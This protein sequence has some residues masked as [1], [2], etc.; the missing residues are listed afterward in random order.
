MN[1]S[2][3]I[4]RA[5]NVNLNVDETLRAA[6]PLPHCSKCNSLARPNILRLMVYIYIFEFDWIATF[7]VFRLGVG[8]KADFSTEEKI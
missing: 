1:C 8:G 4:W 7:C 2:E 6:L 5:D 3:E